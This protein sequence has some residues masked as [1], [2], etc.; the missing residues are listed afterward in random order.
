LSIIFFLFILTAKLRKVEH[1]TKK[2]VS[3]F[4]ETGEIE[5]GS[6]GFSKKFAT[7]VA[8]LRKKKRM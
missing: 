7:F 6:L 1:K 3:F 2:L 4:V 8:K 5:F